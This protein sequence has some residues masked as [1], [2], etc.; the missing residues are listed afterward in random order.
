APTISPDDDIGKTTRKKVAAG[1]APKVRAT[2]SVSTSSFRNAF[3]AACTKKGADTTT[4]ESTTASGVNGTAIPTVSS[5]GP[6]NPWRPKV[7]KSA[8]PNTAGGNTMG[9]SM[10]TAP[11]RASRDDEVASHHATGVPASTVIRRLTSV[12]RKL[13]K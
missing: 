13:S 9:R 3:E 11:T 4:C 7:C 12:V 8:T 10:I 1:D 2:M 5:V 6:I